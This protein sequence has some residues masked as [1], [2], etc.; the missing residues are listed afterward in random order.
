MP[1]PGNGFLGFVGGMSTVA[2]S[3][4]TPASFGE[5]F[6]LDNARVKGGCSRPSVDEPAAQE[7]VDEPAAEK[8]VDEPAAEEP[9]KDDCVSASWRVVTS[10][11][12][13]K[14]LRWTLPPPLWTA[15]F[16]LLSLSLPLPLASD[17]LKCPVP[18]WPFPNCLDYVGPDT[19]PRQCTG[20]PD[21]P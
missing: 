11:R 2:I 18:G 1:A 7:P 13:C 10:K 8:A 16:V 9:C 4:A 20:T 14:L 5:F 6:V 21:P 12:R 19:L 3:T 17:L 15:L